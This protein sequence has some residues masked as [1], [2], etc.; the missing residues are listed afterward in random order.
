MLMVCPQ[1]KA[2]SFRTRTLPDFGNDVL[3][4]CAAGSLNPM[5]SIGQDEVAAVVEHDHGR[6][7]VAPE[8]RF[9]ILRHSPVVDVGT[10]LR[11]SV[12]AD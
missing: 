6:K 4:F 9:G 8:H 11:S 7:V 5:E 3:E 1:G 2:Q 10:G 12:E